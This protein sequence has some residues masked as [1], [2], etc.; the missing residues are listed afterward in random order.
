MKTKTPKFWPGTNVIMSKGAEQDTA[1]TT[2][3]KLALAQGMKFPKKAT[4]AGV[5]FGELF[6]AVGNGKQRVSAFG[7]LP[8][9]GE[10]TAEQRKR[11]ARKLAK[12]K[13]E[14]L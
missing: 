4:H 13:W 9:N 6:V 10:A 1:Q 7:E 11:Y 14:K 8:H 3:V 12:A 5:S 2:L